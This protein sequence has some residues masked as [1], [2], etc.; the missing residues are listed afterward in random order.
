MLNCKNCEYENISRLR[1]RETYGC[2]HPIVAKEIGPLSFPKG[3]T[4]AEHYKTPK[5][6]PLRKGGHDESERTDETT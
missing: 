2:Y 4:V 1:E 5:W 3:M 6:C